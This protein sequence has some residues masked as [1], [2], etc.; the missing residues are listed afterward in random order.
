MRQRHVTS[1]I[2]INV[3]AQTCRC[4]VYCDTERA[5]AKYSKMQQNTAKYRKLVQTRANRFV[6]SAALS[7]QVQPRSPENNQHR[8]HSTNEE[9]SAKRKGV[10]RLKE[11]EMRDS[12]A[13]ELFSETRCQEQRVHV[14]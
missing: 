1:K 2:I 10:S 8:T 11:D 12:A 14:A 7:L 6:F 4:L 13:K 9:L 3:K 5:A